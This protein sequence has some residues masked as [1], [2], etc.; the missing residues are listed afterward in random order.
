MADVASLAGVSPMTVSRAFKNPELVSEEARARIAQA[1]EQLGYVL[2]QTAGTLSSNR[3]GFIS[4][5][6]PSINSSN[7]SDTV[8]GLVDALE[9]EGLQ[10]LLGYTE[11]SAEREERLIE[12][13]LRRR[14]EG[15]VLTGGHHTERARKMLA[16]AGIPIIETWDVPANPIESVVGFSNVSASRALVRRLAERGYKEIGFIGNTLE[17][18]SRNAERCAG[19]EEA[20]AEFGLPK[21][22]I[23]SF[24]KPPVSIEQGA[25]ALVQLVTRHPN[26]DAVVCVS[27]LSAFGAIME[28]HRRNWAV[29]GKIAVAG[30]GNF[31]LASNCHPRISTLAIDCY[32]IGRSAG[33]ILLRSIAARRAGDSVS[34]ETLLVPFQVLEREST[35]KPAS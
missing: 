19:Y 4:A 12:T 22:R 23:I 32:G 10:L 13:M 17:E 1:V 28:C 24:T 5:L 9:V 34:P 14:P 35:L 21:G 18:G 33:Q 31:E 11:H 6:V 7:F 15:V 30:F 29:P 8:R 2:D 26:I 20:I 27:D 3:S 25:E 16:N